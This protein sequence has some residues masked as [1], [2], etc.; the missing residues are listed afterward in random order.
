MMRPS[1]GTV[2]MCRKRSVSSRMSQKEEGRKSSLSLSSHAAKGSSCEDTTPSFRTEVLF[3][4]PNMVSVVAAPLSAAL[5][6]VSIAVSPAYAD[7]ATKEFKLPPIN[8]ADPNRCVLKS[9][10]MGQANAARDALYDLRQCSLSG[11]NA[12][13]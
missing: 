4:L 13:G 10:A 8:L 1:C 7:G 2:K 12:V 3:G 5:L 9:S 6:W 11:S